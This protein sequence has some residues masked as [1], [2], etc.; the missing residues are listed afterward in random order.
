MFLASLLPVPAHAFAEMVRLGYTNCIT[1]HTSST[2]GGLLTEY[3]HALSKEVLS[4]G[5]FFF[6]RQPTPAV[7]NAQTPEHPKEE[8]FLYGAVDLPKWLQL[9]GDIRALQFYQNTAL[10]EQAQFIVMQADAE[11]LA[12]KG[13][14][15]LQATLGRKELPPGL[16]RFSDNFVSHR[17]WLTA[18]L[19]AEGA[20][21][22]L[23]VR[24]GRF[25]P[26]YGLNIP[27][28]PVITRQSLGFDQ[29]QET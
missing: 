4:N 7:E 13:R 20:E 3:G 27:D 5:R 21:D 2:G 12:T 11:M 1:C 28:H 24:A 8:D 17:H 16:S 29:N 23:Q 15:G 18:K 10:V 9:G 25:Y 22:T 14:F 26:A 6:E 19:G